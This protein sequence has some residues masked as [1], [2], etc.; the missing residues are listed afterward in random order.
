MNFATSDTEGNA[1]AYVSTSNMYDGNFYMRR[2]KGSVHTAPSN[3]PDHTI[4]KRQAP[5][6]EYFLFGIKHDFLFQSIEKCFTCSD[7]IRR[8]ISNV[9]QFD[10][11]KIVLFVCLWME[12]WISH[13]FRC[14]SGN[15]IKFN[16]EN[17]LSRP[18]RRLL[19]GINHEP[20]NMTWRNPW[21]WNSFSLLSNYFFGF[22]ISDFANQLEANLQGWK[23][24]VN[25]CLEI[26]FEIKFLQNWIRFFNF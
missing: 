18:A 23:T 7:Q 22:S 13:G 25:I 15:S 4:F 17:L 3:L 14:G 12:I 5:P 19:N 21:T 8:H 24:N 9:I 16:R 1:R 6:W 2:T 26:V 20:L 10:C 11:K